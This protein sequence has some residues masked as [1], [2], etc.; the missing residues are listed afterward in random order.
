MQNLYK[1]EFSNKFLEPFFKKLICMSS[2]K[3]LYQPLT[4]YYRQRMVCIFRIDLNWMK[5]RRFNL[6]YYS[7]V[8]VYESSMAATLNHNIWL[9]L[10]SHGC[11]VN[12]NS[13]MNHACMLPPLMLQYHW[14]SR[15]ITRFKS[16]ANA[17]HDQLTTASLILV[18]GRYYN[19]LCVLFVH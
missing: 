5:N 18:Y 4:N 13:I 15:S 1:Q 19:F 2:L 9:I 12:N 6:P 7:I 8:D 3:Y 16:L 10:G 17:L 11:L 14:P